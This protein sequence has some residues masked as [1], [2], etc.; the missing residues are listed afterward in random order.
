MHAQ[1]RR[2]VRLVTCAPC[3]ERQATL[4][5]FAQGNGSILAGM[6]IAVVLAVLVLPRFLGATT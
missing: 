2:E 4:L 3:E 5:R 1:G 6:A